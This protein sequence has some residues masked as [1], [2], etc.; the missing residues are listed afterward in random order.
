[1]FSMDNDWNF[2]M[3]SISTQ[4]GDGLASITS[5]M[6]ELKEFGYIVYT[7]HFDGTGTYY[8]DDEP[9]LE[10]PY[11]DNTIVVKH[12]AIKKTNYTKKTN[13]KPLSL[14]EEYLKEDTTITDQ[15]IEIVKEFIDYRKKI[16]SPIK[17]IQPI[18][19]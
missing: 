18:K 2:T 19:A 4:Q 15:G 16:K 6:N 3:K 10:N 17:T 13:T 11:M 1:M 8:L 14:L 7:K 12:D 5:A 9:K